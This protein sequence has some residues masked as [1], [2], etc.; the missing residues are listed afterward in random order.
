MTYFIFQLTGSGKSENYSGYKLNKISPN[1]ISI[2]S[3]CCVRGTV[4]QSGNPTDAQF[5]SSEDS[6]SGIK[7]MWHGYHC[8]LLLQLWQTSLITLCP[9]NPNMASKS[10]PT[11]L[12]QADPINHLFHLKLKS[13]SH[14]CSD[15]SGW[16][17]IISLTGSQDYGVKEREHF[18]SR[19]LF[20]LN[21]W[22]IQRYCRSEASS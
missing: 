4:V 7:T 22:N 16:N 18:L 8:Y 10:F 19:S 15:Y 13:I 1:S 14:I 21:V 9:V 3:P 11:Q 5:F 12:F 2:L 6:Y 20:P 17:M